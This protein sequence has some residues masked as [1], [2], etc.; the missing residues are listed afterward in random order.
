MQWKQRSRCGLGADVVIFTIVIFTKTKQIIKKNSVCVI[1]SIIT[2]LL[3]TV[4][5]YFYYLLL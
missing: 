2:Q 4:I 1:V 5:I 3:I